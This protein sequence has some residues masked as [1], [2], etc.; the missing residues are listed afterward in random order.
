M[1]VD[2]V[3]SNLALNLPRTVF[4]T[5]VDGEAAKVPFP[6]DYKV[7]EMLNDKLAGR[8]AYWETLATAMEAGKVY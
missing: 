4:E 7:E 8:D 2:L 6:V 1:K 5:K 3:N